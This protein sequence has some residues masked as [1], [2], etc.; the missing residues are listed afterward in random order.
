M[1]EIT[2]YIDGA[3]PA[4]QPQLRALYTLLKHLLPNAQEKI[5]YAKP[6]F[7]E[8]GRDLVYFGANA[9]DIALYPTSGPLAA[10][11]PAKITPYLH[12]KGA[13]R[14]SFDQPLPEDLIAELVALRLG[15]A[16]P[17]APK[18]RPAVP[19]PAAIAQALQAA[20]LAAAYAA[21]PQYQRTDY[22]NWIAQAKRPATKAKRQAQMLA[23]LKAGDVYMKMAWH[24]RRNQGAQRSRT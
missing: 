19:V 21:R 8:P 13:I 14:F 24:P 16:A 2:D 1:T 12:S 11:A 10:I 6:T 5:S 22:L 20:D 7:Y 17:T 18:R 9:H 3:A 15:G 23:E 4:A